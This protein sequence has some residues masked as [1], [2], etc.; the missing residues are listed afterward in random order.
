MKYRAIV[1]SMAVDGVS[2]TAEISCSA[3]ADSS[4]G[5]IINLPIRRRARVRAAVTSLGAQARRMEH[6]R[7]EYRS[8]A[9]MTKTKRSNEGSWRMAETSLC[10]AKGNLSIVRA[11]ARSGLAVSEPRR[12]WKSRIALRIIVRRAQERAHSL[13]TLYPLTD[14]ETPFT[15]HFSAPSRLPARRNAK[16]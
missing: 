1:S 11:V 5:S 13:K 7:S 2:F 6:S 16:R 12:G 14:S 10:D 4:S 3:A 15:K 8:R 9:D